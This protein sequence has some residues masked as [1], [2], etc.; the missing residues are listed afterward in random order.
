[1]MAPD[2]GAMLAQSEDSMRTRTRSWVNVLWADY[3]SAY[4]TSVNWDHHTDNTMNI[5]EMFS[6]KRPSNVLISV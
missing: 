1:M 3:L 2:E 4:T 6:V 5:L